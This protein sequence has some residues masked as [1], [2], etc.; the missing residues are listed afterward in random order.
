MLPYEYAFWS[1]LFYGLGPFY[2]L[3]SGPICNPGFVP[4]TTSWQDCQKAAE[5]LGHAVDSLALIE[6]GSSFGTSKPPG[7][8][9]SDEDSLFYFN[10][11]VVDTNAL[12]TDKIL[13]VIK[14][15]DHLPTV[16]PNIY[17][18]GNSKYQYFHCCPLHYSGD[19][20][21]NPYVSPDGWGDCRRKWT[22]KNPFVP[23]CYVDMPTTCTDVV[24]WDSKGPTGY[25]WEAC[26][27]RL[28]NIQKI[29]SYLLSS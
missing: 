24:Y 8:F 12:G 19:C 29:S 25:S 18:R 10:K 2:D 27:N 3:N 21:C 15:S 14:G 22:S 4:I 28:G 7:C 1:C 20:S 11:D 9:Q 13:C 23:L 5:H 16:V 6:P 26:Q 17:N